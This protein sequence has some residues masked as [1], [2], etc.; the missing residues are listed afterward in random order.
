ML[1]AYEPKKQT[2][3]DFDR[4]RYGRPV[5]PHPTKV[6]ET[7]PYSRPSSI[8]KVLSDNSAL[9]SWGQRLVAFGFIKNPDLYNLAK[10]TI[11]DHE[12]QRD[13]LNMLV[14]DAL[15]AA[16]ANDAASH[17]TKTHQCLEDTIKANRFGILNPDTVDKYISKIPAKYKGVTRQAAEKAIRLLADNQ[18]TPISSETPCISD[19]FE[20]A[21]TYDLLLHN[22][23]TGEYYIGDLKT[24]KTTAI[25]YSGLSWAV[26]LAIYADATPYNLTTEQREPRDIDVEQDI[27]YVIHVPSDDIEKTQ[28]VAVDTFA[29]A[30]A[31]GIALRVKKARK[32]KYLTIQGSSK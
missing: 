20:A 17:G 22:N 1:K 14:A 10:E 21:G 19:R 25:R 28:L 32:Y 13:E 12:Q 9:Q 27:A 24:S 30:T 29:G 8:G 6:G 3:Y 11:H 15:D 7:V 5:I 18:L 2:K 26:Q 4:D 23:I 31:A 16:G